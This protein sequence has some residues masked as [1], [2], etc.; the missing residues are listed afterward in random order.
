MMWNNLHFTYT[1]YDLLILLMAEIGEQK[2]IQE[3]ERMNLKQIQ[4]K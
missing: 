3:A 2:A 1:W 4:N